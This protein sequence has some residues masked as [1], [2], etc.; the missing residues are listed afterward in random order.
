MDERFRTTRTI[1]NIS[2]GKPGTVKLKKIFGENLIAVR[3]RRHLDSKETMRT[4]EIMMPKEREVINRPAK[5]EPFTCDCGST[6]FQGSQLCHHKVVVDGHN[7]YQED[8]QINEL[9]A[10]NGPYTCTKCGR[11]Y[12]T[13]QPA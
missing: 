8:L 3:Y 12:D 10:P 5:G 4:V 11:E 13:L 2:A 1:K 9:A 6:T 7:S